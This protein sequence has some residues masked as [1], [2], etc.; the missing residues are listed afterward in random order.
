MGSS[1]FATPKVLRYDWVHCAFQDGTVTDEIYR[2]ITAGE[3]YGLVSFPQ[4]EQYFKHDWG[5]PDHTRAKS[6]LL[7][8]MFDDWRSKSSHL[9]EKLKASS[10]EVLAIYSIFRHFV[11][12]QI[13]DDQRLE[14]ETKSLLACFAVIDCLLAAKRGEITTNLLVPYL[15]ELLR[16]HMLL[17]ISAYGAGSIRPKFHWM[18][19]GLL[20]NVYAMRFAYRCT[21]CKYAHM[22]R[23]TAF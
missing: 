2:F 13:G 17:H 1:V 18:F 5:F 15:R 10:G 7:W 8:R 23:P 11:E 6:R 19:K 21:W 4:L 14:R 16:R 9:K 22:Q 3:R 20:N 12:T